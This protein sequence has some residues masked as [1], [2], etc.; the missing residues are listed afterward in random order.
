[1]RG[2]PVTI[3]RR[4]FSNPKTLLQNHAYVNTA[5]L[6][7]RY[8]KLNRCNLAT[9]RRDDRAPT[10]AIC[11]HT[12]FTSAATIASA[13]TLYPLGPILDDGPD[14]TESTAEFLSRMF[15]ARGLNIL[16]APVTTRKYK[17]ICNFP[18]TLRKRDW[19]GITD[20]RRDDRA[21]RYA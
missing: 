17:R 6:N 11:R 2:D 12:K 10:Y 9:W 1:M 13:T 4:I 8:N 3:D 18:I 14:R 20:E 21:N 5:T 7:C 19:V 16:V 15:D